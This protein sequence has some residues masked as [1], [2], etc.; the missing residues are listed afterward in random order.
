MRYRAPVMFFWPYPD[1]YS[2]CNINEYEGGIAWTHTVAETLA[3][4][5][6]SAVAAKPRPTVWGGGEIFST[7]S[8]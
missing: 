3:I 2:L 7:E 4:D 6:T 8:R 1:P 5:G